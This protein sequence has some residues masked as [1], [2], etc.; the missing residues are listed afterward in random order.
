MA[1]VEKKILI[2]VDVDADKAASQTSRLSSAFGSL[3]GKAGDLRAGLNETAESLEITALAGGALAAVV[4]GTLF[5]AVGKFIE[6]D[7]KAAEATEK[8]G[9]A[10]DDLL[11]TLGN[12]IL[13]GDNFAATTDRM[14]KAVEGLTTYVDNNRDSIFEFSK[15][16]VVGLSYVVEWVG[17]AGLGVVTFIQGVVDSVQFLVQQVLRFELFIGEKFGD[18]IGDKAAAQN[19]RDFRATVEA[20]NP[21][22]ETEKLSALIDELGKGAQSVRDFFTGTGGKAAAPVGSA[23]ARRRTGAGGGAGGAGGSAEEL[24]FSDEESLAALFAAQAE[25]AMPSQ[26]GAGAG[27]ASI[28]SVAG[29]T[30]EL[31]AATDTLTAS[32]TAGDEAGARFTTNLSEGL[33]SLTSSAVALGVSL[34]DALVTS[35]AQG[36]ASLEAWVGT[37]LQGIGQIALNFGQTAILAGLASQALPFFGLSGGAAVA[38]GGALVVLGLGLKA[39]GAALASG[40]GGGRGGASGASLGGAPSAPSQLRQTDSRD[41][42]IVLEIDGQ[43]VGAAVAPALEDMAQMGRLRLGGV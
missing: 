13:G 2:E 35:L 23:K 21:F 20:D 11:F 40:A 18:L 38:A 34:A 14:I 41:T 24:T 15:Q 26:V 9:E 37:A 1:D 25:G 12:A 6:Q 27:G 36:E 33:D 28:A 22:A 42:T 4:G 16:S 43:R 5:G 32:L 39:G 19:L 30:R 17:K 7:K 29:D 31:A 8:L 3:R 10:F